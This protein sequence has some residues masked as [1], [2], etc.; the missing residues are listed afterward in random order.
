M[1]WSECVRSCCNSKIHII[2]LNFHGIMRR[3]MKPEM[4]QPAWKILSL[5][6][7]VQEIYYQ[8]DSVLNFL[9]NEILTLNPNE[10]FKTYH[11]NYDDDGNKIETFTAG[12]IDSMTIKNKDHDSANENKKVEFENEIENDDDDISIEDDKGDH[13]EDDMLQDNRSIRTVKYN[14]KN[15]NV[16]SSDDEFKDDK[17]DKESMKSNE[18][19]D[20]KISAFDRLKCNSVHSQA[21][22]K[23]SSKSKSK[24]KSFGRN[25]QSRSGQLNLF[26]SQSTLPISKRPSLGN[27]STTTTATTTNSSSNDDGWIQARNPSLNIARND[28]KIDDFFEEDDVTRA[29]LRRL[30]ASNSK[31]KGGSGNKSGH[32]RTHLLSHDNNDNGGSRLYHQ[33]SYD[34]LGLNSPPMRRKS[35]NN[36]NTA[37]SASRFRSSSS[38]SS[39][40]SNKREDTLNLQLQK[41]KATASS[42]MKRHHSLPMASSDDDDDDFL[43]D[44]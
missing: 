15:T 37:N 4:D 30:R 8:D 32:R 22:S 18:K 21:L 33:N 9:K 14:N 35:E 1:S 28:G 3:N 34:S 7:A 25:G 26:K 41:R 38:S 16:Y 6:I 39:S 20:K 31:T 19:K 24:S 13:I 12:A 36:K 27:K 29:R 23:S 42:N 10:Y 40:I 17:I 43:D 44:E 5:P 2:I 11:N